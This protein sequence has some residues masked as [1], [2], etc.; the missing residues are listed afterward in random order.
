MYVVGGFVVISIMYLLPSFTLQVVVI[1]FLNKNI[2]LQYVITFPYLILMDS[3]VPMESD[4]NSFFTD[5]VMY[6]P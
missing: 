3:V 5:F 2:P 1:L 4:Y 6:Y